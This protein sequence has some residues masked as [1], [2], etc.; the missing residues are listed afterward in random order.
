[1]TLP[2][3]HSGLIG[4]CLAVSAISIIALTS[5]GGSTDG[6]AAVATGDAAPAVTEVAASE[7]AP[8]GPTGAS[9]DTMTDLPAVPAEFGQ[10]VRSYLLE[11]PEVIFE[12]V[13]EYE[14]RMT[15]AQNDMDADLVAVNHD[16]LFNDPH[17]WVGG[18]PEGDITLVKF[19][20]YRCGFCQQAH[21]EIRTLLEA[22]GNI[23]F[24]LKEFPILGPQSELAARFALAVR[25][26]A[27]D[28]AYAAAHDALMV[29]DGP[30]DDMT[31]AMI[32]D[33]LGL[34]P[35]TLEPVMQGDAI[36]R[37]IADTRALAQ[38]LQITGTPTFVMDS[39][40]LRGYVPAEAM[41]A[42]AEELRARD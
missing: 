30:V 38:R 22:D 16:A 20:D 2:L 15:S 28:D 23:R 41:L 27:G 25:E 12:A 35:E 10:Q 3:T 14:R 32:A 21:G 13:A 39:E 24:I 34:D 37:A 42:M 19:S 1:M 40:M 33:D 4:V 11:N 8:P 29:L 36:T 5:A 7:P 9:P 6:T 18:N 31:L 17:V 26:T